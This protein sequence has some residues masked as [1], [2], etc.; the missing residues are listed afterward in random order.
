MLYLISGNPFF[1]VVL[2]A[3]SSRAQELQWGAGCWWATPVSCWLPGCCRYPNAQQQWDGAGG[4][5]GAQLA[6]FLPGDQQ[7]RCP[8][9]WEAQP[10]KLGSVTNF[11][12]SVFGVGSRNVKHH[13]FYRNVVMVNKNHNDYFLR[14][15]ESLGFS[16][17][18]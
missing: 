17:V 3:D 16:V 2:A 18:Y 8:A 6:F 1:S 5:A 4:T 10:L 9:R 11:V 12:K 15:H 7:L 13:L 14:R